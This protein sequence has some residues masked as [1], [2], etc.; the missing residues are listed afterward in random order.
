M[1]E[2][3]GQMGEEEGTGGI[4]AGWNVWVGALLLVGAA[5]LT[6][7]LAA[8][9]AGTPAEDPRARTDS[10]R[11]VREARARCGPLGQEEKQACYQAALET[12]LEE[13]GVA[14]AMTTLEGL[15]VE[16][17]DVERDAHVYAHHIGIQAY[18]RT[19]SVA[20]T[21]AGCSDMFSSGCYHGV[22]QAYF[23]RQGAIDAEAVNGLCEPYKG[24][25]QSRWI[26]FQCLHG[27]GHGLTMHHGHHLPDALASC[28]LLEQTWDRQSCYGGVFME[29][30]MAATAPHHPATVLASAESSSDAADAATGEG[31]AHDHPGAPEDGATEV[32]ER[33][34]SGLY[35]PGSSF[36]ALDRDD[37]HY[38]CS[39][40]EE[41]YAL[42]CYQ[43]QTSAML[44]LNGGDI[45][46]AAGSCLDAPPVWR[47]VCFQSLG[48]DI[49]A[50]V[51]QDA[52]RVVKE[53]R[54]VQEG[55]FREACYFGAVKA[56]VDWRSEPA[57]GLELCRKVEGATY[58]DACYEAFGE[59]VATLLADVEA[60][61][62][63]CQESE[64][65]HVA[66]CRRGARLPT[67]IR[68]TGGP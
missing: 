6:G 45:G 63:V 68:R 50:N 10:A 54:K 13:D 25:G 29:N 19:P 28:D 67:P 56:L 4:G 24:S 48:R 31:H 16:D 7:Y 61:A 37:L 15:Y 21:F 57:P 2:G 20:E 58:K 41:R 8:A 39:A 38:P 27:M 1:S 47:S 66:I 46:E 33:D 53:C 23:E 14:A 59:E 42:S 3:N 65:E 43:M 62:A 64:P 30:V 52:D 55:A 44:F 40:V 12:R 60:R 9:N 36:K 18:A 26:L 32:V 49:T 35:A 11:S 5:I 34:P 22:I 51:L 17:A